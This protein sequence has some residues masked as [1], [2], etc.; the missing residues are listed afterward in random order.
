[1]IPLIKKLSLSVMLG[2]SLLMGAGVAS[3]EIVYNDFG[4]TPRTYSIGT[5]EIVAE[6][7]QRISLALTGESTCDLKSMHYN[8]RNYIQYGGVEAQRIVD[9]NFYY[10]VAAGEGQSWSDLSGSHIAW[11]G[12]LSSLGTS[13]SYSAIKLRANPTYIPFRFDDKTDGGIMKYGYLKLSTEVSG[14][15]V[16]SVLTLKVYS[17]AYQTD[18][19]EIAMGAEPQSNLYY[20]DATHGSDAHSGRHW[21][22]AK[23]TIQAAIDLCDLGGTVWVTNG[24][25]AITTQVS[26]NKGITV[27]SVNGADVTI[28]D[29]GGTTRCVYMTAGTLSG[30]TLTNGVSGA[31]NDDRG[32]GALVF[33]GVLNNCTLSGNTGY[34]GGGVHLTAGMLNNCTLSGN[35]AYTGGGACV[36]SGGELNNCTLSGNA[37]DSSG[38]GASLSGGST[39]NNCLLSNNTST[40]SSGGANV[41]DNSLVINCTLVN[42]VGNYA[43][44]V[45]LDYGGTV[46]NSI[47]WGNL[48]KKANNV[49]YIRNGLVQNSCAPDGITEGVDG[50]ITSDP[51]F[52]DAANGDYRLLPD[53]PCINAGDN[54]LAPAGT[55]LAGNPRIAFSTVDMGAYEMT[56]WL[57]PARGPTVGGNTVTI[58]IDNTNIDVTSVTVGGAVA[59]ITAQSANSVTLTLPA[60]TAGAQDV[61]IASTSAGTITL[62]NAYT[63]N[64]AG[65]IWMPKQSV[66]GPYIAAGTFHNLA[67]KADGSVMAW[68]SNQRGQLELPAE[69]TDFVAV[70][71][72]N[73]HSL[74]LRADG[75]IAGWGYNDYGQ[76]TVPAPNAD[77]VAL[78]GAGGHSLG[79]KSDGTIVAWGSNHFGETNVPEPNSDFVAIAAG[80]YHSL[81]LKANGTIWAWGLNTGYQTT[82]PSPNSDFVAFS[83]GFH[84][85]LGLKADGTI[86][87]WGWNHYGQ[88]EL[89][90]EN[91]NFVAMAC[92]E[93]HSLGLK[94]DGTIVA[95]GDS[96]HGQTDVPVPNSDFVAIAAG[97]SHSL[98]LKA[99][100]TIVAWGLNDVGQSTP[101]VPNAN[102]GQFTYGVN[103]SRGLLGGGYE[104][105][106][107]GTN[108]CNG[109]IGDV[110]SVTL[111]GVPASIVSVAGSTQIVVTAAAGSPGIGDV[112]VVSTSHGTTMKSDAFT[113]L[114]ADQTIDFPVIA[115]Q[116]F[117]DSVGLA[118]TASSGL[119]VAYTVIDGPGTLNGATLTFTA[120]G[121]VMVVAAQAGNETWSAALSVTNRISVVPLSAANGPAAGGN[122]VTITFDGLASIT[123]VLV[124]GMSATITEQA[125]DSVTI[126]MPAFG[127]EGLQDIVLQGSDSGDMTLAGVYTVNP[128]GVINNP[129]FI[130]GG[131]PYIAGGDY[132]SMA[133]KADGSI[134]AWGHTYYGQSD[135]P[136]QNSEFI[137]VSAGASFSMG[138]KNNGTITAW[139]RNYDRQAT[140]PAPNTNFVAIAA[141][142]IHSL[143]VKADGSVV[144]WGTNTL[145]QLSVPAPNSNFVAVAAGYS[146]YSLGLKD[147]GRIV[148]WGRNDYNQLNVPAPNAN[149]VAMAAGHRHALGLKSDGT[150]T[151]WGNNA[152]GQLDLPDPNSDFVAIAAGALHSL[153]L[154]S[155]GSIVAWG[156]NNSGQLDVPAP[157]A[158]FVAVAVGNY[159]SLGLKSDGTIVSWGDN[160]Y[161]ALNVPDSTLDFGLFEYGVTPCFGAYTG[162]YEVVISGTNLCNGTLSDVSAV[163][164]CGVTGSVVSVSGSTQIVVT[165]G[166]AATIGRGDASV[167]STSFG[168]TVQSRAFTYQRVDQAPL[169]FAPQSPQAYRAKNPLSA[170]GGSGTGAVSYSVISGPGTI[171]NG[172]ELYVSAGSGTIVIRAT[173]AQDDLFYATS[174]DATV[175]AIRA[176]AI[177]TLRDL[178]QTYDGTPK[179]VTAM[180]AP[181]G[182]PVEITYD[183]S[184]TPPTEVGSYTVVASVDLENWVGATTNTLSIKHGDHTIDFPAIELQPISASVV[185]NAT[186]S[187]GLPVAFTV[188]D[189]PGSLNGSTLTFTAGGTVA[190]VASQAGNELWYAATPVTNR[191]SVYAVSASSG[192]SAGG[193]QLTITCGDLGSVT[194][195]L[196]G[197]VSA[198]ILEQGADWVTITLPAVSLEGAQDIVLQSS[199]TGDLT[200]AGVY[201]F[202]PAGWICDN[203][204]MAGG[205]YIAAGAHHNL[206]LK[207]D[208]SIEAWGGNSQGQT[209][210]PAPNSNFVAVAAGNS[211]SLGLKADGSIIAW[212]G[213]SDGQTNAPAPNEDYVAIAAGDYHSLGLKADGSVVAWGWN[214]YGQ[215]DVPTANSNFVAVAA[216][217]AHSL[218][219]KADGT[220]VA[221]G[222]DQ[223]WQTRVPDPNSDFVAV[224]AGL[225]HSLG[226]KADGSI[227]AWGGDQYGQASWIPPPNSNFISIAGGTGHTLGLKADGKIVAWGRNTDFEREVPQPNSDFVAMAASGEHSL[228]LKSDGT[229]VAWGANYYG[230]TELPAENA[231]F[232]FFALGVTPAQGLYVGGY[233]V[234]INGTNLCDGTVGDLTSVTLCG[235][236]AEV[237]SVSGSTQIVVIAGRALSAG[238]GD[239]EVV[240]RSHGTTTKAGAF[241]YLPKLPPDMSE[242][243]MIQQ[244]R[245]QADGSVEIVFATVPGAEYIV[246]YCDA[247]GDQWQSAGS[248]ITATDGITYWTDSGLPMT[249]PHP[250]DVPTRFYRILPH[251]AVE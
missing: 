146:G 37:S 31:D 166:L 219:L 189:G 7:E 181:S 105:V 231:D 89:P 104:V 246:Q 98:G 153:G 136:A 176:T 243:G 141:G 183:G 119:P 188:V 200:L 138:L 221:W 35:T 113:Y 121:T 196:I 151:L 186:A 17:Y 227:V 88:S 251:Q 11:W 53:S 127:V 190:V 193:G 235:S 123:N 162:G 92:G 108:L 192:P 163:T 225:Y 215:T 197:G 133:L 45:C 36:L 173:K 21:T 63:Y 240:S 161:G 171:H 120:A 174:A 207:S 158:D 122:S 132:H 178:T 195:V 222:F 69:N 83:T 79:L 19:T 191:V 40:G 54:S 180:T 77:F 23:Q 169:I 24:T 230:Q 233:Q 128:A 16:D 76:T 67:L 249:D 115:A 247:L 93:N 101:P 114:K 154:K 29:G 70:S 74:G 57:N 134:A 159:H 147:D 198:T 95:W 164:L 129:E 55:D 107:N 58:T 155:D 78:A 94:A 52:V 208:G 68:G 62:P 142:D 72:G 212:G 206:A 116:G 218:G 5:T 244:I 145:G 228:A 26:I 239:V 245:S 96:S 75:T 90:T 87:A 9:Q 27:Q 220:I 1:M 91:S 81:G 137:A 242:P 51:M 238:A 73:K 143:G 148:G 33:G 34:Y 103:P 47:F 139:G 157:N 100:G 22:T 210:V 44:G 217:F 30:F 106:I 216:G 4:G 59:T 184:A 97:E 187:S 234:V 140:V 49:G 32:G 168:T 124:G 18:G 131:G 6:T 109:T 42:N 3:A 61:V 224:A 237:V 236:I 102:F 66:N 167:V 80:E 56:H 99:D 48:A 39:L 50:C 202:N 46:V 213:N 82:V 226:L 15:G 177:L 13:G 112:V 25:Y 110:T 209:D 152:Y 156:H 160:T 149:F 194:N 2:M 144:G 111:C 172:T 85:S 118:A 38:G 248:L 150:I 126:T 182:M 43:G 214:Q 211:H 204:L 223:N 165:A 125:A 86:V 250:K 71:G 84:H 205:P 20:V 135:V 179:S 41:T 185:L 175:Q 199:D 60:G 64:P 65:M 117:L 12:N 14:S 232:G 10:M 170:S 229:L 130:A 201:T 28:I 8:N 241:A 203:K